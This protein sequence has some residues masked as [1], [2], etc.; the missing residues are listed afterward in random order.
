MID[1]LGFDAAG[2]PFLS[3]GAAGGTGPDELWLVESRTQAIRLFS[4]PG[5]PP[6]ELGAVDSHGVWFDS[7]R[8]SPNTVWLYARGRLQKVAAVNLPSVWDMFVEGGCIP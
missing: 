2:H 3:V 8:L 6:V 7:F 5:S 1:I 4:S